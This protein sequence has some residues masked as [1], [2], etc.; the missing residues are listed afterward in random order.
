MISRCPLRPLKDNVHFFNTV[1]RYYSF[2][3]NGILPE[4]GGLLDQSNIYIE[5]IPEIG[6]AYADAMDMTI[7]KRRNQSE[8]KKYETPKP[9]PQIDKLKA[10]G[11]E[12]KGT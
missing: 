9:S 10:L 12:I 5:C 1:F 4:E 7:A 2:R 8:D 3:D 6:S 11:V